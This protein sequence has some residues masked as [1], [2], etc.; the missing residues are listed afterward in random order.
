MNKKLQNYK[1]V[2]ITAVILTLI[3]SFTGCSKGDSNPKDSGSDAIS[4][5]SK[6]L[7]SA[8]RNSHRMT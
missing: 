1:F 6:L 5:S 8:E 3:L 7:H 2:A 4:G